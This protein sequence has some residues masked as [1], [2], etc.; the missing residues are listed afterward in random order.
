MASKTTQLLQEAHLAANKSIQRA[1]KGTPQW[2]AQKERAGAAQA[3]A[4]KEASDRMTP[5][6]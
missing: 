1:P 6:I 5:Q 4:A 3:A 2:V